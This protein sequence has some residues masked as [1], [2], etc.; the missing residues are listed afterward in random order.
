MELSL[1]EDDSYNL[2]FTH[3]SENEA[4]QRALTLWAGKADTDSP[5]E[6]AILHLAGT[7]RNE[8]VNVTGIGPG[9][10]DTL[11]GILTEYHQHAIRYVERVAGALK[12]AGQSIEVPKDSEPGKVMDIGTAAGTLALDL[13]AG[14]Y[15][16][17]NPVPDHLPPTL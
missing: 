9:Q 7:L 5:A 11:S 2:K 4:L 8:T 16:L 15:V 10:I 3:P 14:I 6:T 1:A 12:Q 13:R 17:E